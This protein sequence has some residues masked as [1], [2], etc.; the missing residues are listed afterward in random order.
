MLVNE[1]RVFAVGGPGAG[2]WAAYAVRRVGL[3]DVWPSLGG[4]LVW[5][6]CDDYPDAMVLVAVMVSAGVPESAVAA[7]RTGPGGV[8]PGRAVRHVGAMRKAGDLQPLVVP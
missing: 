6:P 5:V 3:V 7:V 1:A 2:W 4:G 8:V